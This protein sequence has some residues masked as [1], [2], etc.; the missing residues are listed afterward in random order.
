VLH[1]D[2]SR[3]YLCTSLKM[4]AIYL[5]FI[6]R[7]LLLNNLLVTTQQRQLRF[8]FIYLSNIIIYNLSSFITTYRIKESERQTPN[9]VVVEAHKKVSLPPTYYYI[10]IHIISQVHARIEEEV[11]LTPAE[12]P[13]LG[14]AL[15]YY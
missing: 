12:P 13:Q 2:L 7:P 4:R 3:L 9:K 10:C 15:F 11:G 6:Y 14:G 5:L 1:V 8:R